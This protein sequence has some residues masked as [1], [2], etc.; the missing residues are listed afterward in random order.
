MMEKRK[1]KENNNRIS[2]GGC[3]DR[4]L[5]QGNAERIEVEVDG[6]PFSVELVCLAFAA[7]TVAPGRSICSYMQK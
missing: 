4:K 1:R 3:Y 6:G 2:S 5:L 7:S